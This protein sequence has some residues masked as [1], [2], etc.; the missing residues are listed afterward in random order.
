MQ[1]FSEEGRQ[2]GDR[3]GEDGSASHTLDRVAPS[4]WVSMMQGGLG[5]PALRTSPG[6]ERARGG[7]QCGGG[8]LAWQSS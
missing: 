8:M 5:V 1:Y 6:E 7:S 4:R 2:G 3:I